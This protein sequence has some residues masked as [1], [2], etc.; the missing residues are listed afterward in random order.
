[1]TSPSRSIRRW[2]KTGLFP[3]VIRRRVP[4]DLVVTT[5]GNVYFP[6]STV[7]AGSTIDTTTFGAWQFQWLAGITVPTTTTT[8]T[9]TTYKS[10]QVWAVAPLLAPGSQSWSMRFVG[11]ADLTAA[12]TRSLQ[13]ADAL[14]GAGNV[15]LNDPHFSGTP[16]NEITSVVRTGTGNQ[17]FWL[18]ATISSFRRSAFTPPKHS[19]CRARYAYQRS[20]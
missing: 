12:D 20:V 8:T 11:G 13:T 10:G 14:A 2:T 16:T 5:D 18:A 7:P 3:T 15:T 1:M 4:S 9:T 19:D 17:K 6:G